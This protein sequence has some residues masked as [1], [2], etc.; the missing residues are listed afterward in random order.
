M[1]D[2]LKKLGRERLFMNNDSVS[3]NT[4]KNKQFWQ[5]HSQYMEDIQQFMRIHKSWR[6]WTKE[7]RK[8]FFAVF[9][10]EFSAIAKNISGN[11]I[12]LYLF[13][14]ANMDNQ[15]GYTLI[16]VETMAEHFETNPRTVHNWLKELKENRLI[17]RVQPGFKQ[18]TFTFL[19]PYHPE[20]L[21][22]GGGYGL[23]M[24]LMA[25]REGGLEGVRE[26]TEFFDRRNPN[27]PF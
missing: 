3:Q 1:Y 16:S 4:K 19:L 10:P 7:N 5:S 8:G 2:V 20:F 15:G 9:S 27:L 14:G 23:E 17:L 21:Q 26:I 22:S 18:A 25:Y 12:K 24:M 13:L 11:A 6:N